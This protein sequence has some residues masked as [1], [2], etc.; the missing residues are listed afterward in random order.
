MECVTLPA[1]MVSALVKAQGV[2][3]SLSKDGE[4]KQQ[5]FG[6][7]SSEKIVYYAAEALGAHGLHLMRQSTQVSEWER[8]EVQGKDRAAVYLVA[9]VTCTFLLCH[10]SGSV[11][12]SYTLP[13][14]QSAGRPADKAVLATCTELLGYALR[15]VLLIAR[16]GDD[17]VRHRKDPGA[18]ER[19][20]TGDVTG[21]PD[22]DDRQPK[23]QGPKSTTTQS[24]KPAQRATEAPATA[25]APATDATKP[26][27]LMA[28]AEALAARLPG[29][30]E[31]LELYARAKDAKAAQ[32]KDGKAFA[33]MM[34]SLP[35][36]ARP[37]MLDALEKR[38][39]QVESNGND[40]IA[41]LNALVESHDRAWDSACGRLGIAPDIEFEQLTGAQSAGLALYL[42]G[43]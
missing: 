29:K 14:V 34:A 25:P 18:D 42:M 33:V 24:A 23:R 22:P 28:R 27:P 2:I 19:D 41:P 17:D 39:A 11:A 20:T 16:G 5:G 15:D 32:A 26:S 36:S 4:N 6:Y 30:V 9:A 12:L 8:Q 13:A 21:R 1:A 10:E 37:G 35:E 43:L 3:R 38:T 40:W 7:V 31:A